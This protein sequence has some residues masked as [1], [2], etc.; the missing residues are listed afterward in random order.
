[1]MKE[2]LQFPFVVSTW[3]LRNKLPNS[4]G[5][6]PFSTPRNKT[7]LNTLMTIVNTKLLVPKCMKCQSCSSQKI[8]P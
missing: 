1:M 4:K 8:V 6:R 3:L 7:K 2:S 5:S